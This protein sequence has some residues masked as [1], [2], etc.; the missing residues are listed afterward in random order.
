MTSEEKDD[1][2]DVMGGR[3]RARSWMAQTPCVAPTVDPVTETNDEA[4]ACRM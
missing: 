1:G 4:L 2:R 3:G